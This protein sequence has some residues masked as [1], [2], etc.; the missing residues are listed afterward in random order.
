M[1]IAPQSDILEQLSTL[2]CTVERPHPL[3]VAVDGVDA[4]GKT[5]LADKLA[6]MIEKRGRPVIR[7]SVDSFHNPR[8]IRYRRGPNSPEGQFEE[9]DRI[10]EPAFRF[11]EIY[12]AFKPWNNWKR[13]INEEHGFQITGHYASLY[14]KADDSLSGEDEAASG[15][16]R[17]NTKWIL[18][19]EGKDSGALVMTLDHRHAY[20]D[21]PPAGLGGQVGYAG[22][23]GVLFSDIDW[24]VVNLN[25]QQ[26]FNDG[27]TGLLIGRYDS[28]DYLNILG[29]VNP[30]VSFSNVAVLLEPSVA[31]G[32][33][34]WGGGLGHWFNDQYYALGGVKDANG[35]V[36]D[37]L[38]FFQGG[39]EFYSFAH[40]GWSPSRTQRYTHN[41]HLA[42]WHLDA[43]EDADTDSARGVSLAANWTFE[44]TWMPFA[45]LGWSEGDTPIYNKS[46]SLGLLRK[47][48]HRS[49]LAG[50]GVIFY[51]MLA[52][53]AE[54]RQRGWFDSRPQV[55]LG[56]Y[57]DLV[58][59]GTVAD[60]VPLDRNNRILVQA[61]LARIRAGRGRVGIHALLDVAARRYASAVA[62]DLGFAVGP[63]I[64]AAGRLDDM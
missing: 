31:F 22:V 45:R 40:V 51:I 4:A 2:V 39:S 44:N 5:I 60:V 16:F 13:R 38:E 62:S 26:G 47:F 11:G 3:R 27:D 53:R 17:I 46:A 59:L 54:L 20:L 29:Y 37:E 49:D 57:L 10:K 8:R 33:S 7:A 12:D 18:V 43:R 42:A 14:Q 58:A 52:L 32:D 28:N 36:D 55:N 15:V 64:N 63:R 19:G 21:I 48:A 34:S 35:T 25:W 24:T 23:T 56:H 41:V 61:G 9:N 30:W 1:D 50:V 6:P